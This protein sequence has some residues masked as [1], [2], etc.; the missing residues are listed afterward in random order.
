MTTTERD[1]LEVARESGMTVLLDDRIGRQ[2]YMS[3]SGSAEALHRFAL[4]M[5]ETPTDACHRVRAARSV[6][7]N[8]LI[9]VR[10]RERI[11]SVLSRRMQ[12]R[13]RGKLRA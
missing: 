10:M 6:A 1:V 11:A 9:T 13:T 5:R 2:E 7:M 12:G 3:V 8:P 4:A